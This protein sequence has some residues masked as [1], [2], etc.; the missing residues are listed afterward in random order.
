MSQQ[1]KEEK[2]MSNIKMFRQRARDKEKE[3]RALLDK[4]AADGRDLNESEAATYDDQLKALVAAEKSIEREEALLDRERRMA[5]IED[6]SEAAAAVAGAPGQKAGFLSFGEFLRAVVMHERTKGR[7]SDPRLVAAAAGMSEAVPSD[8]GFL[9]QKDFS[10]EL[11]TRIYETGQIASRVTKLP[12]SPKSNGIKINAIDEDSRADGSRWG[13]VQAYWVNEAASFTGSK[14]K[15]RQI[16][17]QT[18][19]LIA[20]CYS[21]DE[22]LEDAVAL[23]AVISQAFGQ[24]MMFKVEDAILNGTGAGQPLGILNSGAVIQQ[25]KDAADSGATITT[26]DVLNMWSRLW[27]RSRPNSAWFIDQSVEPKLYA[28][29]L[30]S[31]TAVQLLYTPPGQNGNQYGMLLGRPVIPV[32]HCAVLGTPGDVVLADLSQYLLIDKGAPR[33]DYSM[34][35]NFLTDEGVFRFVYR[36]DGQPS[37]KKPLTPKSAGSTLSPFISLATRS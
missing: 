26:T 18:Q 27:S 11:L 29:T 14:P 21:T 12:I 5:P 24:E 4:A 13:G 25:A 33:Q 19:K 2:A 32:E 20:L 36:V 23:E 6:P 7:N 9:V 17:L 31:G 28:L 1:T 34:H 3:M 37:W 8:G 30:G 16:E 35:V 10:S 22:L 15:F